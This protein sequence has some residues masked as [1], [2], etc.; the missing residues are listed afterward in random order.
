[1]EIWDRPLCLLT[2]LKG[3]LQKALK[4]YHSQ[5]GRSQLVHQ[6]FQNKIRNVFLQV[7]STFK[8]DLECLNQFFEAFSDD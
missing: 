1:M 7:L 4:G 5:S 3:L 2:V 6:N 8:T